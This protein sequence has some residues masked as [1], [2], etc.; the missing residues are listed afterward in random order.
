MVKMQVKTMLNFRG[1]TFTGVEIL[2]GVLQVGQVVTNS[3][4]LAWTIQ[5]E[6]PVSVAGQKAPLNKHLIAL[7][8]VKHQLL[9]AIN[10]I[11]EN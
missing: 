11:L 7:I 9:P 3:A 8:P 10:D 4:G 1:T 6:Q 5:K 2:D